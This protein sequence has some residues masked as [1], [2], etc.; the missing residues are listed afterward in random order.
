MINSCLF[1][2]VLELANRLDYVND[3]TDQIANSTDS[4]Y[5][6]QAIHD[7][8]SCM[9][10]ESIESIFKYNKIGEFHRAVCIMLAK[11]NEGGTVVLI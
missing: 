3:S 4:V 7:V 5:M 6:K 1:A 8:L 10:T 11:R 9:K 2:D